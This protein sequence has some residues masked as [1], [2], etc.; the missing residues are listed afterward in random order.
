MSMLQNAGP[1]S[2]Q[3]ESLGRAAGVGLLEDDMDCCE[4][5]ATP[6]S[7]FSPERLLTSAGPLGPSS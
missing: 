4:V 2:G 1:A 3:G 6:A 7:Q 5:C